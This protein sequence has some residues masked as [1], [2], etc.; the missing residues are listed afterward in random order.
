[1][2]SGELIQ[3]KRMCEVLHDS[4]SAP[5]T[6]A[7]EYL[8]TRIASVGSLLVQTICPCCAFFYTFTLFE[9]HTQ[10]VLCVRA[11]VLGHQPVE[12][13]D[14]HR[15]FVTLVPSKNHLASLSRAIALRWL[16]ENMSSSAPPRGLRNAESIQLAPDEA[17]VH[18]YAAGIARAL[19]QLHR[20]MRVGA[21]TSVQHI[22]TALVV[23][24]D[25][26]AAFHSKHI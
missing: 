5:K 12:L 7:K 3:L 19:A 2:I 9:A 6:L 18:V 10:T 17:R 24:V 16:A 1:M 25:G 20:A 4:I 11:A 8:R 14:A 22:P 23:L 21:H 13:D 26:Q 15:I